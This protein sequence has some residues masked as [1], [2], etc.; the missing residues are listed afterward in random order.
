MWQK[1]Q[2]GTFNSFSL[3]HKLFP[4]NY[5]FINCQYKSTSMLHKGFPPQKFC[6]IATCISCTT[7]SAAFKFDIYR[8]VA[9]Y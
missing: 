1:F 7:N 5:G 3:N 8:Q 9:I 4:V 6:H 2:G